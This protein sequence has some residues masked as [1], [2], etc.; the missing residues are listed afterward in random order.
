MKIKTVFSLG[1]IA[2]C[3]VGLANN[4]PNTEQVTLLEQISDGF[5]N[6]GKKAMPATVFIKAEQKKEVASRFGHA[7]PFHDEF[8]RRFF[9]QD[10]R[11]AQPKMAS[12]SGVIVDSE[13]RILTNNHVIK[14]ADTITVTMHNGK[15]YEASLLGADP[16]TDLAILQIEENNLPYLDL[17]DSDQLQIGHLVLAIGSPFALEATLTHGVV[18]ALKRQDLGITVYDNF[19]QTDAAINPGNS[20]GPLLNTKG[21]VIGINTAIFTHSGGSMGIGFAIPSNI[22]KHVMD[23]IITNGSVKRAYLGIMLQPIDKELSEALGL[24]TPDGVLIAQVLDNSPA[25]KAGLRQ[26]DIVTKIDGEKIKSG[27]QF[28]TQV[29]L[30]A[31]GTKVELTILRDNKERKIPVVLETND[32]DESLE[33]IEKLGLAVDNLNPDLA[34]KL[35]QAP[36]TNG[37]VITKVEPGSSAEK[38]GLKPYYLITGVMQGWGVVQPIENTQDLTDALK[39]QADKKHVVLVIRHQNYQ[40]Y[41]TLKTK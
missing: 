13:G 20:G 37:V 34:K 14:D 4:T 3:F 9:G 12:G 25:D 29:A 16:K 7:D 21:E 27:A 24:Q 40:R 30:K 39:K 18:S 22:A 35:G 2:L 6:I 32:D 38:A 15:E 17:G 11:Q 19:I 1:L 5:A 8:F 41:Y 31:P 33:L 10:P 26:G 23:Q 28:R 36:D